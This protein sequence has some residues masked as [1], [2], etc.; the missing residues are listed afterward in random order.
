MPCLVGRLEAPDD[1]GTPIDWSAVKIGL[2]LSAPHVGFP[3]DVPIWSAYRKFLATEEGKAYRRTDL[4]VERNGTFLIDGVPPG[5][6][7]LTVRALG[8]AVAQ[9][10]NKGNFYLTGGATF[11]VDPTPDDQGASAIVLPAISLIKTAVRKRYAR[12][13]SQ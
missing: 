11:T 8:P 7:T 10:D 4:V 5:D 3:G 9:P 12:L 6:Y 13:A 2:A 1:L